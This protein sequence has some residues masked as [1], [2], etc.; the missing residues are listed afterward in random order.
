MMLFDQSR[1]MKRTVQ[2][3]INISQNKS[4]QIQANKPQQ[5]F[6][7]KTYT[8]ITEPIR[9]LDK[10][11]HQTQHLHITENKHLRDRQISHHIFNIKR[12]NTYNSKEG[13]N[14]TPNKNA[15]SK[16]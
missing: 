8:E 4:Q 14:E 6:N 9:Q 12:E 2:P 13:S 1:K 16:K 11:S 15:E 10:K 3:Y 5:N 7:T